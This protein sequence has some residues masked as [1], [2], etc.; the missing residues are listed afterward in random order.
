MA[1]GPGSGGKGHE[2]LRSIAAFTEA[3]GE[4]SSANKPIKMGRVDYEYAP[5]DFLGGINPKILFD[6][7]NTVSQKRYPV[8]AGYYPLPGA[9]VVL[10]PVGTTYF[11]IGTADTKPQDPKVDIFSTVG[12][13]TWTKPAGARSVLVQ[14]QGGGGAGGGTNAPSTGQNSVGSG[15]AG[16]GYGETWF[17]ANALTDTVTVTVGAGGA[18]NSGAAGSAGSSSSFGGYV[19]AD[20]GAGGLT[21]AGSATATGQSGGDASSQTIV[22]DLAVPGNSGGHGIKLGAGSAAYGGHGGG[23]RLGGGGK[24]TATTTVLAG[25]AGLGYGG[26][27]S[28]SCAQG[29][30]SATAGGAGAQGIVIVTTFF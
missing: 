12:T 18:G 5:T 29:V 8:M 2:F 20:G 15:G 11:I 13:D 6:G 19:S 1:T 17:S 28:G 16:G 10:V 9:R 14:V 3:N 25:F 4:P 26:A 30:Q 23:S 7:E 22:A 21:A 27:G 24:G